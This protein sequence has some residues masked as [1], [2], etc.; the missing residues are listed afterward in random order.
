MQ[1]FL[2]IAPCLKATRVFVFFASLDMS[3][4]CMW[5]SLIPKVNSTLDTHAHAYLPYICM[6]M[7]HALEPPWHAT[8]PPWSALRKIDVSFLFN[9][10]ILPCPIAHAMLSP[11]L[12]AC[13]SSL[14]FSHHTRQTCSPPTCPH[15]FPLFVVTCLFEGGILAYALFFEF[16]CWQD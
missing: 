7:P 6:P 2:N 16:L 9:Q 12:H 1:G 13:H 4:L 5:I 10:I 11:W 8:M 3:H 14:G 15:L